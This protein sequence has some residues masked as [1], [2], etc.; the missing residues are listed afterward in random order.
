MGLVKMTCS[1]NYCE[2]KLVTPIEIN[3]SNVKN[4]FTKVQIN[5]TSKT[6]LKM[7]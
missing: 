1:I 6:F 3:K 5:D 2:F 7:S 4:Y